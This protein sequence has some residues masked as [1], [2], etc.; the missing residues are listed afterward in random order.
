MSKRQ[1]LVIITNHKRCKC[2][3]SDEEIMELLRCPSVRDVIECI[4]GGDT[5]EIENNEL[6]SCTYETVTFDVLIKGQS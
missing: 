3:V 4:D 2:I 1:V 5:F 6:V